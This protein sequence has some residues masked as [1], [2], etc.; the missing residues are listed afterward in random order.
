MGDGSSLALSSQTV[1][2]QASFNDTRSPYVVRPRE[3]RNPQSN[4]MVLFKAG[5]NSTAVIQSFGLIQTV[6]NH[7]EKTSQLWD[8]LSFRRLQIWTKH[9]YLSSSTKVEHTLLGE[10][11]LSGLRSKEAA[12]TRGKLYYN[13]TFILTVSCILSLFLYS[14]GRSIVILRLAMKSS[15]STQKVSI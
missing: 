4:S 6:G 1:G 9:Y 3:H 14:E 2:L 13:Y 11:E 8:G 5:F 7:V 12:G 15:Q 10:A